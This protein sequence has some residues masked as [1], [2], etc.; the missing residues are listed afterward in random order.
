MIDAELARVSDDSTR[1]VLGD[2]DPTNAELSKLRTAVDAGSRIN[3]ELS[4]FIVQAVSL[5]SGTSKRHAAVISVTDVPT[6][7]LGGR[8]P[9]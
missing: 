4:D 2:D 5:A 8:M 6:P 1:A 9:T 3:V 7:W